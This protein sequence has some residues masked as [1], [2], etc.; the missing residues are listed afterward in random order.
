MALA[1]WWASPTSGLN[2]TRTDA[3]SQP[4]K[5]D[6][7]PHPDAL[8]SPPPATPN[9]CRRRRH[10]PAAASHLRRRP[11]CR[12]CA[13]ASYPLSTKSIWFFARESAACNPE[14][15]A[16]VPV[17]CGLHDAFAAVDHSGHGEVHNCCCGTAAAVL[18]LSRYR[19]DGFL[20]DAT[21]TPMAWL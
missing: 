3:P 16:R 19:W 9:R 14:P 7:L 6:P 2:P 8:L 5:R 15:Q 18:L 4:V 10:T 17:P 11:G 12:R 20:E 1:Y 21:P 13:T